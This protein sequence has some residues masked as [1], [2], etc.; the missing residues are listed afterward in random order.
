MIFKTL[1]S[2]NAVI[3]SAVL[4]GDTNKFN[5]IVPALLKKGLDNINLSMFSPEL[6]FSILTALGEGYKRKGNLNDA[7]KSF[8]LA[9]NREKLNEVA[10]DYERLLQFHNC[11]EVYKL[12][13]NK[14]KLLELGKIPTTIEAVEKFMEACPQKINRV[15]TA[16]LY[17]VAEDLYY[18]MLNSAQAVLM[19]LG[20]PP[21]SP[22]H[23]PDAVKEHLVIPQLLEEVYLNDIREVVEFRKGVEHKEIKELSGEKLDEFINK[24][25]KFVDR[26][27]QLLNTLQKKRKYTMIEKNYEVMIKAAVHALKIMEKLPPD[28]KDLPKAIKEDL[29][30]Q[31]HVEPYHGDTFRRVVTMRKMLDDK[32]AD[33]IPLKDLELTRE[34]V[35]RFVRDL[36]PI[37]EGKLKKKK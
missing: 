29:I 35:R 16:K 19:Y 28:P 17:M 13:N 6:K 4:K 25:K 24:T 37:I 32:K 22:K 31:G 20:E 3:Y 7:V 21:P 15:E 23:C 11:I 36:A 1:N 8:V 33:E 34:Y 12:S 26:M 9:G 27:E 18:A 5:K 30:D 2:T 10:K 14:E